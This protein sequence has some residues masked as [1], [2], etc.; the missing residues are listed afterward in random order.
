MLEIPPNNK[1]G[2]SQ[3]EGQEIATSFKLH[4]K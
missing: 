1:I 2:Q 3:V 4:R